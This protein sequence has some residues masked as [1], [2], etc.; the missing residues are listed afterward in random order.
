M[1]LC[2]ELHVHD[3]EFKILLDPLAE[4]LGFHIRA[5]DSLP[6]LNFVRSEMQPMPGDPGMA[7]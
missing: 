5:R 4:T 2:R 1:A 7:P 6:A 3:R